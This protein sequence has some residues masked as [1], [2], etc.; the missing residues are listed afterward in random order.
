MFSWIE[1]PVN[2]PLLGHADLLQCRCGISQYQISLCVCNFSFKNI[3]HVLLVFHSA[4]KSYL[5]TEYK[6]FSTTFNLIFLGD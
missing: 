3:F 2:F 1:Q 4:N 6:V 5:C